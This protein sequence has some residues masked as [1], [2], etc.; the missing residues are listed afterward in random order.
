MYRVVQSSRK[1]SLT[2]V[3]YPIS[4]AKSSCGYKRFANYFPSLNNSKIIGDKN[5]TNMH[6]L[7]Y[8]LLKYNKYTKHFFYFRSLNLRLM[9]LFSLLSVCCFGLVL[10]CWLTV[11]FDKRCTENKSR[12]MF[13]STQKYLKLK[14]VN[15]LQ[16]IG[17]NWKDNESACNN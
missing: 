16:K 1:Y 6:F 8:I 14:L 5:Y 2:I 9:H 11:H 15:K 12:G 13:Q 17:E 3:Q 10:C 7:Y 4:Q